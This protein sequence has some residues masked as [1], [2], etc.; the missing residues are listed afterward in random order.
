VNFGTEEE[1]NCIVKEKKGCDTMQAMG[2][3][4]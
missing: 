3:N 1:V 4:I 2:I